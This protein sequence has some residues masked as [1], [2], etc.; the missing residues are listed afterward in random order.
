MKNIKTKMILMFMV[1]IS[2]MFISC[3]STRE[4]TEVKKRVVVPQVIKDSLD[5]YID[6]SSYFEKEP[7]EVFVAKE[8]IKGDTTKW[9]EFIPSPE[10][11]E[12]IKELK[13]EN[14]RLGKKTQS[15]GKFKF[16][17]KPDTVVVFDTVKTF[18]VV[19]EVI[20]TPFISKL[21][22]VFI[23]IILGIA[24]MLFIKFKS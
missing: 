11:T 8:I 12:K 22:L 16:E 13:I 20:E 24:L 3:T 21:G 5:A 4:I 6:T 17:I 2:L 10:L 14:E 1:I 15:I 19:K 9:I 7:T 18:Q 23:G